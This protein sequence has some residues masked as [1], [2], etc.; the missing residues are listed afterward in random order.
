LSKTH[1]WA[2]VSIYANGL[3]IEPESESMPIFNMGEFLNLRK[4]REN[5]REVLVYG[6]LGI[7]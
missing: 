1:I 3:T 4:E 5:G 7:L 2:P 6:N